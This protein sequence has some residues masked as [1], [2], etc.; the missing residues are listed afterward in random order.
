MKKINVA[1]VGTGFIGPAH[2]EAL[3]RLPNVEVTGLCEVS[4]ELARE[5]AKMLGIANAYTFEDM[6]KVKEIDI[7]HICT[8][9]F[10][11]FSQSKAVLDPNHKEAFQ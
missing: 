11:H 10:L 4:I 8:P 5:K 9:N 1:I 3:R 2:L 6:L 7:V